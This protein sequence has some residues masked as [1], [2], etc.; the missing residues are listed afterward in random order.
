MKL[1]FGRVSILAA[2]L[3]GAM[4]SAQAA[5]YSVKIERQ[6]ELFADCDDDDSGKKSIKKVK[7]DPELKKLKTGKKYLFSFFSCELPIK[8]RE[9][10]SYKCKTRIDKS[11]NKQVSRGRTGLIVASGKKIPVTAH[12]PAKYA[13]RGFLSNGA[14]DSNCVVT[15]IGNNSFECNVVP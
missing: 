5:E 3:L 9:N 1:H 6:C 13:T 4:S 14:F 2:G 10:A 8:N 12:L 7:K 11:S 15:K